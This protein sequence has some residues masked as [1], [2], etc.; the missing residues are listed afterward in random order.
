MNGT[1]IMFD[2]RKVVH[3]PA[4]KNGEARFVSI[5]PIGEKFYPVVWTWRGDG[6]RIMSFRRARHGEEEVY[7]RVRGERAC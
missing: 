7:H 1:T 3:V 6:R 4:T 5:A 2:G